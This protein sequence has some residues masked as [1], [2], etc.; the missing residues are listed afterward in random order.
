M[1]L[2]ED[3]KSVLQ[4]N[5][6]FTGYDIIPTEKGMRLDTGELSR[7]GYAV[8]SMYKLGTSSSVFGSS[9]N[10]AYIILLFEWVSASFAWI[11]AFP[12][13]RHSWTSRV[14]PVVTVLWSVVLIVATGVYHSS[15]AIPANNVML[16]IITL[17]AATVVHAALGLKYYDTKLNPF[18]LKWAPSGETIV[19]DIQMAPVLYSVPDSYVRDEPSAPPEEWDAY[20]VGPE[21]TLGQNIGACAN[22]R[23]PAGHRDTAYRRPAPIAVKLRCNTAVFLHGLNGRTPNVVNKNG[24]CASFVPMQEMLNDT[25]TLRYIEYA[26]TA[27]LLM[28]GTQSTIVMNGPIWALQVCYFSMLLCNVIGLAM[29]H[30]ILCVVRGVNQ[31]GALLVPHEKGAAVLLLASSWLF[32][33]AAWVQFSHSLLQMITQLP[34]VALIIVSLMISF[35]S[36]FGIAGSVA[37]LYLYKSKDLSSVQKTLDWLNN[38]FDVLSVA[39]KVT[40]AA[41][42]LTSA[43]LGPSSFC[44]TV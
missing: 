23:N 1:H 24:A 34:S 44:T 6:H 27:P 11:Y 7:R 29:H 16:G 12:Y 18:S 5:A 2:T 10:V 33:T 25:T 30:T 8:L 13:K 39:V 43:E 36:S 4:Q 21:A 35:Y 20:P 22:W 14:I 26:I 38:V 28:L 32:F 42:I 37:F 31:S 9:I 15:W 17:C 41:I 3:F 40:V 19:D